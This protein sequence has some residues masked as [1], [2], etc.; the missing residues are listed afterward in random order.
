[1]RL[2]LLLLHD[3][4]EDGIL[5]R[6]AD[7]SLRAGIFELFRSPRIDSKEPIPPGCVNGRA[8]RTTLLLLG[9]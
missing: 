3:L 8:G 1:M 9:S 5:W 4:G 7:F 6:K 2:R